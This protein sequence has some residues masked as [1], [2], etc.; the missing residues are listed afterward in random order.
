MN[1]IKLYAAYMPEIN[2]YGVKESEVK[3]ILV[4]GKIPEILLAEK[5]YL[6]L[7]GT[8]NQPIIGIIAEHKKGIYAI[9]YKY[10]KSL[11]QSGVRIRLLTYE[12]ISQQISGINGLVLEGG[13]ICAPDFFY[14]ENKEKYK[15][16]SHYEAYETAIILAKQNKLPLLGINVG[17]LMIAAIYGGRLYRDVSKYTDI[18]HKTKKISAH[19]VTLLP[20]NPLARIFCK[21]KINTNSR[22]TE[23]LNPSIPFNLALY[24]IAEDGIPEAW[25]SEEQNILC[26][27][28]HPED[29]AIEGCKPMQEIFNWLAKKATPKINL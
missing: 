24:A 6:S 20:G 28:W 10:A 1:T 21:K 26:V 14:E 16:N 19:S 11:I 7:K 13:T 9:D 8:S 3:E 22:H 15:P 4:S 18:K 27:Q 17:A 23:A 5:E 2:A 12:R 25:G 29:F